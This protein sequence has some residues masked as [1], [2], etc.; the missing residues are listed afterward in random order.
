MK[1]VVILKKYIYNFQEENSKHS[2]LHLSCMHAWYNK[3]FKTPVTCE[4]KQPNVKDMHVYIR[5]LVLTASE[6]CNSKNLPNFY[7]GQQHE[8]WSLST[9]KTFIHN[10]PWR[11]RW[12]LV[13][14]PM[15]LC[16][17]RANKNTKKNWGHS[18]LTR[19][20]LWV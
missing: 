9:S 11:K 7:Y 15:M 12:W 13:H 18:N 4:T 6:L 14:L 20:M 16:A 19:A 5:N 8:L 2:Y 17:K 3:Q 10:P 1:I